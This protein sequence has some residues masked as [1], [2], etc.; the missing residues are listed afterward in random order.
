M[1]L[2]N[3]YCF[4]TFT[5]TYDGSA[6]SL[7]DT[8]P[9]LLTDYDEGYS[10]PSGNFKKEQLSSYIVVNDFSYYVDPYKNLN[11][12]FGFNTFDSFES[13]V[14]TATIR[15]IYKFGDNQEPNIEMTVAGTEMDTF[16]PYNDD[17]CLYNDTF[18][19]SPDNPTNLTLNLK[20]SSEAS[21][22][23][24]NFHIDYLAVLLE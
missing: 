1:E 2:G 6:L 11:L 8:N 9:D 14:T 16:D 21:N 4:D 15:M 7:S 19:T 10:L 18:T 20:V 13:D 22:V 5:G 24:G 23:E 3:W 12:D 17:W